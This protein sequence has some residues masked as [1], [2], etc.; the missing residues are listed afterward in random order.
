V[1]WNGK[2]TAA[3]IAAILVMGIGAGAY[4]YFSALGSGTGSASVGSSTPIA[5]SAT[6]SGAVYPGGPGVDV[7]VE[8][9]NP[10]NGAQRV[11]T[12]SLD[13][14]DAPAG[15]NPAW[16]SM[17]P[18]A[19]DTTVNASEATTVH[20]TLA[21]QNAAVNQDACQGAALTLHVSSN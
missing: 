5:L 9:R 6:T 3:V 21:M 2:K 18:I 11:H 1:R 7:A 14:I 17:S 10:G 20:G 13:S 12:V 4:A 19:V 15:C 8:V 16:F